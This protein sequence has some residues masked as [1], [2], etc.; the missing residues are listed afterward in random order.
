MFM[1]RL[2][3]LLQWLRTLTIFDAST[4]PVF[5]GSY[6]SELAFLKDVAG[7]KYGDQLKQSYQ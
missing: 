4:D 7:G 1:S 5:A 3:L 6:F 2:A